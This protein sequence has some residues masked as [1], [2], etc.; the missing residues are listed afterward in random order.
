MANKAMILVET[1]SIHYQ[2]EPKYFRALAAEGIIE[3]HQFEQA[4]YIDEDKIRHLERI[5]RLQKDLNLD[6]DSVD[7]IFTLLNR[8]EGLNAELNSLRNKIEFYEGE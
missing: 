6:I 7:I 1:L 8:I 5:L 2:V 3:I 4:D